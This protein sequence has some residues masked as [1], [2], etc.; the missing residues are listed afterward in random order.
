MLGVGG[1]YRLATLEKVTGFVSTA[2][3]QAAQ[4]AV[5]RKIAEELGVRDGQVKAA[6]DLLDGGATVPFIARYRKEA[7]GELD[8]AQL[9]ALEERLRYLRELE[10]RRAAVLESV[11]AQGKLDD[12]LRAQILGA[13]SKARLEDIYLPF[14]PKRRTKAQIAREAGLEPLAQALL[15]DPGLDPQATAAGYLNEAVAD[16][17]AALEGARAI[18][19]ERFAED[20]DLIGTLRERMWTRGRLVAT[21]RAGKE[22]DGAKFSDYFD[23]AEPYTRLPSHRILAMLRGEK[24]EILDLELSPED[25]E[26]AG[27]LPGPGDY[28]QRIA[29]RFGIADHGRPGDRWLGDTVRWAWRTRILVRLGIDLRTRLRQEAED[30]AVRVFAANL[31][32]LLLAAPAGTRATMGLDPGFR[33]GVKVA[34]VDATGKVLAH[35]TIYPHQPANKWDAALATLAALARAHGVDLIAIGNGTA[36]R[37]TDKLAEDLVKRHPE[38][39]L[40][41]A[42]VSEAGASVYSASA[43]ASQEL[44]ELNVSIRGA[45]SIARRLQDPLAELVKIDPKSIGVGQYQHDLSEVKLSRSLDAVVED[46]VN[47]VGVDVNTASAPLLTRVSGITGTLAD[48]IVAHRDANGPFR[49]RRALKDVARLG[50]KAFEQCAGFLRIPGGDDPLDASSVHPEAYPVVRR[51]LA[52]TGGDLRGLIG[53]GAALRALR[54]GDF[55]D[56]TFGIPTVTDILGELDKPGRDPRPAFKTATFKE[57]VDKIGDLEVG[58]VLEGVVT[59][60][61]AFGAFVD[62]GVHQD[63][64]VHVSALSKN[65]VKDPREVVKPGDIVRVRVTTVDVPRKRIGLTLRLDDEVGAGRPAGGGGGERRGQGGGERGG[66]RGGDR[67][68]R[69]PRQDRRGSGGGGGGSAPAPVGNSAMADALRRAG[70]AGGGAAGSGSGSGSGG[71]SGRR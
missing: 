58:M 63:G 66:D 48:N 16:Q 67:G 4:R 8:D 51:I 40:T 14:K 64:L 39:K 26:A 44:P 3:E 47:A 38:L 46:C 68:A 28:E 56:E 20:A 30:E 45:V 9:R 59:N 55:A 19:V 70:L 7:T 2:V 37:E 50:P 69:P 5:E 27:D 12:A 23:F 21:V 61:A 49:T 34:V 18:L 29:A 33:T 36:S 15:A 22:Q 42:M 62:V 13:D 6:V 54:P 65:F 71:R 43:F 57:G 11:E 53:N 31:R 17:A 41:K 10:E 52:A 1:E 25:G 24:E 32:D 35:D 60:V